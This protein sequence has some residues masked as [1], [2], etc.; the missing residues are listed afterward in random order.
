MSSDVFAVVG[1]SVRAGSGALRSVGDLPCDPHPEK[2]ATAQ[3][4]T[5]ADRN[6]AGLRNMRAVSGETMVSP[7]AAM[8]SSFRDLQSS[9]YPRGQRLAKRA[10]SPQVSFVVCRADL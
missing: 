1:T 3:A 4:T 2:D 5:Q 8:E 6:K 10:G 7:I 9:W